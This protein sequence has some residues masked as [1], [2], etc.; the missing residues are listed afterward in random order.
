MCVPSSRNARKAT[1]LAYNITVHLRAIEKPLKACLSL[2]FS[3]LYPP[4]SACLILPYEKIAEMQ[5]F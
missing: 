1:G 4:P 3:L 5:W 2:R